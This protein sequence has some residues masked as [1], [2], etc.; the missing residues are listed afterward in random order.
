MTARAR[1]E[2]MKMLT[3]MLAILVAASSGELM[4]QAQAPKVVAPG[5]EFE[6]LKK[7]FDARVY[8]DAQQPFD[9]GTAE[10]N[11]KYAATLEREFD[12]AQRKGR[13]DDAVAIK[14]EK[15]AITQGHGVPVKDDAKAPEALKKLRDDYR[16]AIGRMEADREK[17]RQPLHAAFTRAV[18]ALVAQLTKSG[19]L[20]QAVAVKKASEDAMAPMPASTR[21]GR[22]IGTGA[23]IPDAQLLA[24]PWTIHVPSKKFARLYILHSDHTLNTSE[25]A[26]GT[27]SVRGHTLR[28]TQPDAWYDFSLSG[29]STA[30]GL[31]LMELNSS[32]GNRLDVVLTQDAGVAAAPLSEAQLCEKPWEY[33][34]PSENRAVVYTLHPDKTVTTSK[35]TKGTWVIKEKLLRINL[36][37]INFW[38]EFVIEPEATSLGRTIK[39]FT[40][41]NGRKADNYMIQK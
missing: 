9:R 8:Q 6:A 11:A 22:N 32:G 33:H 13:L 16:S 34:I 21:V 35:G 29:R 30:E 10:L 25:G 40:S 38:V 5:A 26:K 37:S 39:E 19:K 36:D 24:R 14:A 18:D 1:L 17:K 23:P 15:D 3:V 20:D 4:A 41:Q 7:S 27:W 2:R 28:L 31:E 12:A